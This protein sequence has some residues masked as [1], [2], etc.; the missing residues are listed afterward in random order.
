MFATATRMFISVGSVIVGS[1]KATKYIKL[2]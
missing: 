1:G 2:Y